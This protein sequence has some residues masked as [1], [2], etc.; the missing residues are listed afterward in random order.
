MSKLVKYKFSLLT[1]SLKLNYTMKKILTKKYE[2]KFNFKK[3]KAYNFFYWKNYLHN[4]FSFDDCK[5]LN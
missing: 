3:I 2:K 1:K 4:D 5:Q